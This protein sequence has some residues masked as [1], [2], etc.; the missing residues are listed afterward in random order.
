MRGEEPQAVPPGIV[1]A[2]LA[3]CDRRG[4]FRHGLQL[5]V[6][7]PVRMMGGPFSDQLAVLDQLD[8]D[9]R[10]RVLLDLMGRKVA[11]STHANYVL[12]LAKV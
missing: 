12:P 6:G 1:E 7:D 8:N 2:L 9:G 10:V 5:N 3:S 11:I 4:I